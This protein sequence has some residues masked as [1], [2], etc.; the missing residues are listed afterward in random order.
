MISNTNSKNLPIRKG[1]TASLVSNARLSSCLYNHP[2]DKVP[3]QRLLLKLEQIGIRGNVLDWIECFL[4][5]RSQKVILEDIS[6]EAE[7]PQ[8]FVRNRT[9][10]SPGSSPFFTLYRWYRDKHRF[11]NAP[12]WRRLSCAQSYKARFGLTTAA[13]R[14]FLALSLGKHMED[15]L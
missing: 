5:K 2:F 11:S 14:Y 10:D 9:G 8:C 3:H 4:T 7:V 12:F 6:S 1:R 13:G 15:D